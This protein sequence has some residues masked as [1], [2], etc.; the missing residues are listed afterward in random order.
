MKS[1]FYCVPA[2]QVLCLEAANVTTFFWIVLE[3]FYTNR[4]N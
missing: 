1:L 2:T 3:I 4:Q